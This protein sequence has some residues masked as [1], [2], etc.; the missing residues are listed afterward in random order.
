M[1][2]IIINKLEYKKKKRKLDKIYISQ[3]KSKS[4]FKDGKLK[5]PKKF[6]EKINKKK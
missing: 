2:N 6:F 5:L 3:K 1:T 4:K